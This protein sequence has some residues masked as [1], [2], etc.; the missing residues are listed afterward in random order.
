MLF[1]SFDNVDTA[2][3][4]LGTELDSMDGVQVKERSKLLSV[5][6]VQFQGQEFLLRIRAEGQGSRITAVGQD[7]QQLNTGYARQLL[8][9]LRAR[10]TN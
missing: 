1:R 8:D 3:D 4:R 9:A 5:Y 7:G 6:T 2:W 10:L